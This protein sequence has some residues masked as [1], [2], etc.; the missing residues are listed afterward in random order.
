MVRDIVKQINQLQS[1]TNVRLEHINALHLGFNTVKSFNDFRKGHGLRKNRGETMNQFLLR[2]KNL[3][4]AEEESKKDKTYRFIFNIYH[5]SSFTYYEYVTRSVN[6]IEND[7]TINYRFKIEPVV[8]THDEIPF[9]RY[10][11]NEKF[12]KAMKKLPWKSH[13]A[14][15]RMWFNFLPN[16]EGGITSK[17]IKIINY[18]LPS[19]EEIL[20]SMIKCI[21]K[22]VESV[23]YKIWLIG[24]DFLF[25]KETETSSSGG[26]SKDRYSSKTF[27]LSTD[28]TLRC[29][30]FQSRNNNCLFS[31]I[32]NYYDTDLNGMSVEVCRKHLKFPEGSM[33]H[34]ND[35]HLVVKYYNEKFNKNNGFVCFDE[36]YK[37]V[38]H[39]NIPP[40]CTELLCTPYGNVIPLFL[41]KEHYYLYEVISKIKC[42]I[43]GKK[44]VDNNM[45]SHVCSLSNIKFKE[46]HMKTYL[47]DLI[48]YFKEKYGED[49]ELLSWDKTEKCWSINMGKCDEDDRLKI[50]EIKDLMRFVD[51]PLNLVELGRVKKE[52]EGDTYCVF[53]DFEAFK[54]KDQH[55]KQM[56]YAVGYY[57]EAE[58]KYESVYIDDIIHQ[59]G[60]VATWF[61]EFIKRYAKYHEKDKIKLVAFNGC[62]Y[63]FHLILEKMIKDNDQIY[64]TIGQGRILR[65]DFDNVSVFDLN[66]FLPGFSL[67]KAC[68]EFKISDVNKK[69][70]FNH[71]KINSVED[72]VTHKEECLEYMKRDVMSLYE[73]F[74]IIRKLVIDVSTTRAT[75]FSKNGKK[76]VV[77][78]FFNILNYI[79]LSHCGYDLWRYINTKLIRIPTYK[80]YSKYIA[81]SCHGGRTNPFQYEYKS[82]HLDNVKKVYLQCIE[83]HKDD[84]IY[85]KSLLDD[86]SIDKDQKKN[87][88]KEMMNKC[89]KE[90]QDLYGEIK[91]SMKDY[92]VNCDVTSLYPAAM[93]GF[94]K[95]K[96]KLYIKSVDEKYEYCVNFPLYP[97]NNIF[98]ISIDEKDSEEVKNNKINE[99][100][101][102]FDSG[103]ICISKIKFTA[104]KNISY[105]VLPTGEF[106][107]CTKRKV[108][109]VWSLYDG[110]GYYN[111]I[112]IEN[113]LCCGYKIEFLGECVYWDGK[114]DVFSEYIDKFITMKNEAE[115]IG[116]DAL[117]T[118]CK[119]FMNSLYGK[120]LQHPIISETVIVHD[121]AEFDAFVKTHHLEEFTFSNN[122]LI[123]TGD[124]IDADNKMTKPSQLG[125]LILAYSRRIMLYY[126]MVLDP[127]LQNINK[128]VTYMDTDSAHIKVEYISKLVEMGYFVT[129]ENA[130]LGLFCSDIKN[131]GIIL[132]EINLGPKSYMYE[133]L[134]N[135]GLFN[136]TKKSKGIPSKL[137]KKDFYTNAKEDSYY[138]EGAEQHPCTFASFK[139]MLFKPNKLDL[140]MFSI[141]IENVTRKFNSKK[142]MKWVLIDNCFYPRGHE[143]TTELE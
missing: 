80:C 35:I 19:E 110:E 25:K 88:E 53:F 81:P 36:S 11:F 8:V 126:M 55:N 127:T 79:T 132:S 99:C 54:V 56:A 72:A 30:T 5:V 118:I 43:C 105:P 6:E 122:I 69:G 117:R 135:K 24:Y 2:I 101:K 33:I 13:E 41:Y 140:P 38:S 85:Y 119:L 40:T 114:S 95:E 45:D 76:R 125:S 87:I 28:V 142:W 34:I 102:I 121:I 96:G 9:I 141:K 14:W 83:N 7:T 84:L 128:M 91:K 116:N 90:L 129:K 104:P 32:K 51:K 131:E 49:N 31:A 57:L 4:I 29:R 59:F 98:E 138:L 103:L 37:L 23:D 112:D 62:R 74:T 108:G 70:E 15:G 42:K 82:K 78:E 27:A 136:D 93:S 52:D 61:K 77:T 130:Q 137:L 64:I 50:N 115:K 65:L 18:K 58:D 111:S 89:F 20:T 124:I 109:V 66:L 22:Q 120:Q 21:E 139:K 16:H 73:L 100:K 123:L 75:K 94:L 17:I 48:P 71:D 134:D 12:I 143:L 39:Y 107:G 67:K 97:T 44:I 46:T 26:C 86:K 106:V 1:A 47:A 63:D 113:A 68:E 10:T 92:I 133:Y 3:R 60:D